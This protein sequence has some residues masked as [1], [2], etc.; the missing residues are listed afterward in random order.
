MTKRKIEKQE[1][2][3]PNKTGEKSLQSTFHVL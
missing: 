1:V 2:T 3:T